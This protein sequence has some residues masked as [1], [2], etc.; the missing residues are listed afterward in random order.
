MTSEEFA[1]RAKGMMGTMYRVCY[2]LVPSAADRE[3]AVQGSLE[4]AFAKR[5]T[6]R[7]LRYFDT[8]LV[9]ILINE[10]HNI[11]RHAAKVSLF[12]EIPERA[13]LRDADSS[14]HDAILALDM[15]LKLPIVLHYM[16][17]YPIAEVAKMLRLPEGTI[18]SRM[19]KAREL[20]RT[21]LSEEGEV[22]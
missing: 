11:T 9:R 3:D 14:L 10:C 17:G 1:A 21:M 4:K 22:L 16:Q 13:A 5:N 12:G 20:L 19:R 7:E 6:L 8:W 15:K 18:K 2:A